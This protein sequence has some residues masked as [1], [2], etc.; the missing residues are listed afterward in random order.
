[1]ISKT[2][3]FWKL[4]RVLNRTGVDVVPYRHTRHPVARRIH[5]FSH[6][7]ID[8]V[9][10]VG[11]NAGQYG[12][13][14][15]NIGYTGRIASFE[16]L[17]SAFAALEHARAGDPLWD[18]QRVA[19]S[20]QEGFATLNVAGNSES[21]SFL[22]MLPA[23]LAAFPESRYVNTERVPM[24]T[25]ARVVAA[26]PADAR[27][28]L[29][30]DTQGYE[31][32]VLEGAGAAWGRFSGVQLEMSL[33]PCYDGELLIH[34]MIAYMSGHGFVLMSLEPGSSDQRTGQLLQIDGLFFRA[35]G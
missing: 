30:V 27:V 18:A 9:L 17:S 33:V 15:R 24:T 3:V 28:F 23:H 5:L 19:L 16:P 4:R 26:V 22:P 2:D 12:R 10:D 6:Y 25:L 14:L 8:L 31:R 20:N 32:T 21:S 35:T 13:F 11:A 34:E 7:G 29:K 1:M